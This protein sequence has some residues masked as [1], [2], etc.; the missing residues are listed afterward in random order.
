MNLS[1]NCCLILLFVVYLCNQLHISNALSLPSSST[2]SRN[3]NDMERRSILKSGF[4]NL[5]STFFVNSNAFQPFKANAAVTLDQYEPN[6]AI[7][8]PKSGRNYFPTITP[9]FRNRATY[10]YDLGRDAYALEQLLTFGNVTATIRT[11]VQRLDDGSLWV[12]G[13][14][15]PTGE[16]CALLDELGTVEH[17][18]LP[19]N[20]I[21]HKAPMEAFLKKY[22]NVKS[23]WIAPGQ[24]G[25]FGSCDMDVDM[26]MCRMPYKVDGVLPLSSSFS[27][28]SSISTKQGLPPWIDEFE[29]RTLYINLPKNAGPVSETAF[30]HK[31]THTLITTDSVIYVPDTPP[32]IFSTYFS[33][34]ESKDD[35]IS[36][37]IQDFWPKTVLQSIFLPLRQQQQQQQQQTSTITSKDQNNNDYDNDIITTWPGYNAIQNRLIRAPILRSFVDARAPNEIRN[38]V[39]EVS[40][41]S[42]GSTKP[43]GFDRILTAHFASPIQATPN[44]FQNAFSYLILDD[45]SQIRNGDGSGISSNDSSLPQ[46]AC[47]DWELLQT[48]N[49]FIDD[50]QLGAP[51]VFDYKKGCVSLE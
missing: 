16:Y 42:T 33:F 49:N 9:P 22:P 47:Q 45:N 25:F 2:H 31:S 3:S 41:M 6:Q 21:E 36:S 29:F 39:Q 30:F 27:S 44:D 7:T 18:V 46:I 1:H 48:L 32:P 26:D 8:S 15:Y 28:S 5:S 11:I 23:V 38:W 51:A 10:R 13:P 34:L 17:V 40:Q 50:Y 37:D 19:C 12:H 35:T 24:Y 20:A 43:M 4:I 14:L